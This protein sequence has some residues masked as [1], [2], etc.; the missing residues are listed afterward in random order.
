M[1]SCWVGEKKNSKRGEERSLRTNHNV[2]ST[3]SKTKMVSELCCSDEVIREGL[4]L[5]SVVTVKQRL[6]DLCYHGHCL[7]PTSCPEVMVWNFRSTQFFSL[8]ARRENGNQVQYLEVSH[9]QKVLMSDN[10][11]LVQCSILSH[12]VSC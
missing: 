6:T 12:S 1:A 10:G 5:Q 4:S 8:D 11:S 7:A 9:F 3:P 2:V